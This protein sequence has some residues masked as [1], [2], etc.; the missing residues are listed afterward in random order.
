MMKKTKIAVAIASTILGITPP[1]ALANDGSTWTGSFEDFRNASLEELN[2]YQDFDLTA[3]RGS[4]PVPDDGWSWEGKS[5]KVHVDTDQQLG[6]FE[7]TVNGTL[8]SFAIDAQK[9][10]AYGFYFCDGAGTAEMNLSS[11]AIDIKASSDALYS[12]RTNSNVVIRDFDVLTFEGGIHGAGSGI[13]VNG[14]GSSVKLTGNQNSSIFIASGLEWYD[15][16]GALANKAVSGNQTDKSTIALEAGS[17]QLNKSPEDSDTQK[18]GFNGIYNGEKNASV[19]STDICFETQVSLISNDNQVYGSYFGIIQNGKGSVTLGS[20]DGKGRNLVELVAT[21]D[22]TAQSPDGEH[23]LIANPLAPTA[24]RVQGTKVGDIEKMGIVTLTGGENIVNGADGAGIAIFT[25][26]LSSVTLD[27]KARNTIKGAVIAS[28]KP[29]SASKG[30]LGASTVTFK[31]NTNLTTSFL[32]D[33]E[34]PGNSDNGSASKTTFDEDSG[35]ASTP[36]YK[37]TLGI[38]AM[39]NGTISFEEGTTVSLES[40]LPT[41]PAVTEGKEIRERLVW[42]H[43]GAVDLDGVKLDAR[44]EHGRNFDANKVGIALV[45]SNKGTVNATNL[46]MGSRIVGDVVGGENGTVNLSL[47]QGNGRYVRRN[48][49]ATD[50]DIFGNALAGNGGVVNVEL[51][52]G[53][54]WLGRAD[55]YRDADDEGHTW[56]GQHNEFFHPQFADEVTK[57]GEVNI[58]LNDGAIWGIMGQSWVTTLSGSGGII[59]LAGGSEA[60]SH[61]LRVWDVQGKHTFVLDLNDLAHAES[62]MLYLKHQTTT[63]ASEDTDLVQNIVIENIQGL[64]QMQAGDR[65]RFATVDGGISFR[66]VSVEGEAD[67][68]QILDKGM[69]NAGFVI[70]NEDYKDGDDDSYNGNNDLDP[71]KPGQSWVDKKFSNGQNW[72]LERDPSKDDPS[73]AAVNAFDMAKANYRTA[74]YLDT[75]NKRQGEARFGAGQDQGLW[76]RVR[77]D[78]INQTDAFHSSNVMGEIGYDVRRTSD[79]GIHRTGIAFDYMDGTIE[80]DGTDSNGDMKRW[81]LWLY[82]TWLGDDGQYTDVVLKWGRLSND[83]NLYAKSSNDVVH[84]S[85]DNDVFSISGEYGIKF[86]DDNGCYVE[87]QM[88]LQYARVT[89]ADYRTSQSSLVELDAVDSWIGRIGARMGRTWVDEESGMDLYIKGDILRE[90]DGEQ[91]MRAVDNTGSIDW[92][93]ANK[94]TWGDFGFGFT[95]RHAEDGYAFFELEKMLGNDYGSSWQVSAGM[96]LN[97]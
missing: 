67:V 20:Q 9:E 93:Y 56:G 2:K 42:A 5:L 26:G 33:Y 80:Y 18:T 38:L 83:F 68:V 41:D 39:E 76:A 55:D 52:K 88:Q 31:G 63:Y 62:D 92:V 69:V 1:L 21:D 71:N 64:E 89:S 12:N 36:D 85:Y 45:A 65:I 66:T 78:Q 86:S 29:T 44:T 75:L 8:N 95:Y 16:D 11:K 34:Q 91:K 60:S 48:L 54:V 24:I 35:G 74:V 37:Y 51:G 40:K 4:I 3:D 32:V 96:R 90:F 70:G 82:D 79:S 73:D 28:P 17:I 43:G 61:A 94:G 14:V 50:A 7:S 13:I 15:H 25:S 23:D 81:G 58:T 53:V 59:D 97:F 72:F 19:S 6:V 22:L 57:S 46:M 27:A 87:P 47:A 49:Q 10:G 84:G 30:L 77:R